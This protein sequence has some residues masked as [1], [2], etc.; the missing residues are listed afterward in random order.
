[1]ISYKS[2][3]KNSVYQQIHGEWKWA[4]NSQSRKI[5]QNTNLDNKTNLTIEKQ[6]NNFK[7]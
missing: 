4:N 1:M 7:L 5:K 2:V 6:Y 3:R